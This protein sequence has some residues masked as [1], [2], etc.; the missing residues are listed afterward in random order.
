[1]KKLFYA[2]LALIALSCSQQNSKYSDYPI[3]AV[4]IRNVILADNF[5]LPKIKTIQD[6]NDSLCI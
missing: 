4:G 5:W 6:I 2:L 1:M 3:S